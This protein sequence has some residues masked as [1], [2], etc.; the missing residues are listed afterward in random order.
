LRRVKPLLRCS[1]AGFLLVATL[2]AQQSD[3][4]VIKQLMQRLADSERRIQVLEQKLGIAAAVPAA[5]PAPEPPSISVT[6]APQTPAAPVPPSTTDAD[7]QAAVKTAQ[8]EARAQAE[9]MQGHNM[10]LPGGG[11]I[12]NIRGFFDFN[13]G[14]GSIANPLVFPIVDNGCSTCGNPATPPHTTFQAG[15]FDLFMTSKLSD[16]L[17]FLAEVVLGPDATNA[18]SVDIERYQLTYKASPYFSASAGRFHTSIGYYNTAYHHGNWFSTAEGRPIMY[19][20][21]D[22]GGVLPVHMVGLSFTGEVPNSEKLGLHWVAEVG[23]GLSSNPNASESVQNFYS[24]RN[25]KATNLAV[26]IKPQA[27]PGL[28]IGGSWYHDGLNPTQAQNPL[29]FNEVKQN[30]ESGYVV[31][32]SSNWEF[33]TEGVLLSNHVTGTP[34]AFRSPMAYTQIARAF[35]IYKPY[36]RYQYVRDNPNDP[37]NILRGTYYGPSIGLRIDFATYA[38]FKLQYNH[39]YQS[40]QLAGNGLNAQIAFAF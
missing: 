22:S 3:Q 7:A 24:D 12:L 10:Q 32:F 34:A 30:I 17:S 26:Y 35:G 5:A 6:Q 31:Y 40:S 1:V 13:F 11:P 23:N 2:H 36:F 9:E 14:V 15:E 8:A 28:Q 20:F 18:F 25:Y 27:I 33:L 37:V 21:E 38:A 39:L 4:E 29:P 16:H 19:L